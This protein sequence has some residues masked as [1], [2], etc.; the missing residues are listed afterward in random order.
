MVFWTRKL[1]IRIK[2]KVISL[3]ILNGK[4]KRFPELVFLDSHITLVVVS[5]EKALLN[6]TPARVRYIS[7]TVAENNF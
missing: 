2:Y 4:L 1:D 3:Q 6:F 5:I 7:L